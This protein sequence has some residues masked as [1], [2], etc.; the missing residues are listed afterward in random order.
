[1]SALLEVAPS[2]GSTFDVHLEP[3]PPD[4]AR[5][6]AARGRGPITGRTTSAVAWVLIEGG[7]GELRVGADAAQVRGRADVFDGPGWS[8]I[9][10][11]GTSFAVDGT[12]R[13]TIVWRYCH[14]HNL[15]SRLIAPDAVTEVERGTGAS[16]RRV[17][18]Y[19]PE[20]PLIAGETLSPPGGW[21]SW[22][23]HRH[24][25]EEVYLYRFDPAQG[26]GISMSYGDATEVVRVVREGQVQRIASGY[27]PVAAAP[28][29]SMYYLWA[30]A[31]DSDV[32]MPSLDPVHAWTE[33]AAPGEQPR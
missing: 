18:T 8:G 9:V 28:G 23:P 24:E 13:Y 15:E 16:A 22:P 4:G 32:L 3:R 25:H 12:I 19:V 20:G 33:K 21:S 11:P 30:L 7:E 6:G 2:S 29:Y 1:M 10:P 5:I 26:F 27:H 17:R 31:G 14:R